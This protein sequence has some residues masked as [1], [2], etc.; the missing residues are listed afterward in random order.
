MWQVH[1]DYARIVSWR[2]LLVCTG[3][4][5]MVCMGWHFLG[6]QYIDAFKRCMIHDVGLLWHSSPSNCLVTFRSIQ[7]SRSVLP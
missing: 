2:Y 6:I 5:V 1:S 4:C 7:Y 3:V